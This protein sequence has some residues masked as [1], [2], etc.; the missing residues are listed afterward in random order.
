MPRTS[1]VIRTYNEQKLLPR[2]LAAIRQ[3]VDQ[4][5]RL[6]VVDSGSTDRTVAIAR[7]F[8]NVKLIEMR[9]CEFT[10]G[11]ALNLGI[12]A[13]DEDTQFVAMIS[14]HAIPLAGDWLDILLRPMLG[15]PDV[16]GV[17]G[18]QRPLPEHMSNPVVRAL[19][20]QAYHDYY[21][22]AAYVSRRDHKFSNAN[23]AIR[24]DA[25]RELPFDET[26]GFAEDQIWTREMLARGYAI[27]YE[28]AAAVYHSHPDSYRRYY[29]RTLAGQLEFVRQGLSS[30]KRDFRDWLK[31]QWQNTLDY[32]RG[33]RHT[34]SLRGI[35]WDTFRLN[36]VAN[37]AW[38]RAGK[39]MTDAD[40]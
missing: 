12:A 18:K 16:V 31:R 21:G 19:A 40:K 22:E 29:Y 32:A 33:V 17:F 35:H 10:Y 11:R 14:A 39:A 26:A 6:V 5:Y 20:E 24:L 9:K 8:P 38:Y 36:T 28:P 34:C 27:A 25:W 4:D 15:A 37:W 7:E 3:Q 13:S 1:I 23:S 2:S 30:G